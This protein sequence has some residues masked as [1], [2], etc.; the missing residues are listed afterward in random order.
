M[1]IENQARTPMAKRSKCRGQIKFK[2]IE[3]V[4]DSKTSMMFIEKRETNCH[5]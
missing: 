2:S 1:W 3:D 5:S 4:W